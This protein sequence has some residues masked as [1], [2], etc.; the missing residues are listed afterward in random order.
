MKLY[1][2]END[3][4]VMYL[5]AQTF[6]DSVLKTFELLEQKIRDKSP[7]RYFGFS[8]PNKFGVIEYKACAEILSAT[9]PNEYGLETFVI[10]PGNYASIFIPNHCEDSSNI[11][12]AFSDLLKHPELDPKGF[13][14][15]I[16]KNYSDP[17]VL[18]I[19]PLLDEA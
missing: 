3:I 5:T 9:E 10:K 1:V 19:V 12:K 2:I 13:C 11:P 4:Q 6:P 8:H 14:L 18:C 16:Y 15:E 17:D 7:R